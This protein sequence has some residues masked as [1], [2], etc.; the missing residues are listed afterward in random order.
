MKLPFYFAIALLALPCAVSQAQMPPV[1]VFTAA[2]KK[3]AF[4]DKIEAIGSL[5]ANETVSLRASVTE[6]VTDVNFEDG[7]RVKKGDVLVEMTSTE[8]NAMLEEA[9]SSYKEAILQYDRVKPLA[10]K[11]TATGALLDQ[12]RREMETA[13]A[14]L[15]GVKSQIKDRI[16]EAPF[17][18]VTG[19]RN[20][21]IGAL[22]SP[23]DVIT[24]LDD[25]SVMKLDFSVPETYLPSLQ[26]G[27][28]IKAKS[29]AFPGKLFEGKVVSIGSQID[30][31][32]RSLMARA[33]IPNEEKLLRPGL[34]MS[35]DL[36][37]DERQTIL[38]PEEVLI[39]EGGK[40]FAYVIK[41]DG[42]QTVA[43]KTEIRTA[44][45]A[46]GR[47]EITQGLAE[48]DQI[49][50]HGALK[51]RDGQAVVVA[52]TGTGDETLQELLDQQ[53]PAASEKKE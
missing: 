48:G 7:V 20:I 5:R 33:I 51:I 36:M 34:L 24:T 52:A 37:K 17:D 4:A 42:E 10:D 39:Q 25:D 43:K 3:S 31:V 6:T 9:E 26:I 18:G 12:R 2:V 1:S 45:R 41:K 35:V 21:S 53:K 47:V 14:R 27:L 30:P 50:T 19:F 46:G 13:K 40:S 38:I 23:G 28:A 22:L 32:T 8:E 49:V 15:E 16:I 29:S 11:G 44:S